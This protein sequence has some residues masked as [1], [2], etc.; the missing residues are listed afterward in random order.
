MKSE[1]ISHVFSPKTNYLFHMYGDYQET[2]RTDYQNPKSY[3]VEEIKITIAGQLQS[4]CL[5]YTITKKQPVDGS[6]KISREIHSWG[7][8]A[9]SHQRKQHQ[10]PTYIKSTQREKTSTGL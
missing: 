2:C 3:P 5:Q 1:I 8:S 7:P 4:V 6:T 10:L 9:Q